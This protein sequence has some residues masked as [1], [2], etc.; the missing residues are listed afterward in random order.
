MNKIS[1]KKKRLTRRRF[2]I[3]KKIRM[4]KEVLRLCISRNNRNMYAQIIDDQKQH[5]VVAMSTLAKDFPELKNSANKDAAKMLGKMLGEKAVK[6]GIKKVV[7]DRNG[8]KYHG[9]VKAFA[10]AARESGLEF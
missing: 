7:F 6:A 10:D 4:N 2:V 1:L 8:F 5:T 3:K 9:R